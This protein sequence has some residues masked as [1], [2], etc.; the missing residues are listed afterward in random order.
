MAN[1]HFCS[2]NWSIGQPKMANSAFSIET[3]VY[4]KSY[5]SETA[6]LISSIK[7]LNETAL[8]LKKVI[9]FENPHFSHKQL[10]LIC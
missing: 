1:H 7:I 10:K 3:S 8:N 9:R 6:C 5:L 4:P 2:P